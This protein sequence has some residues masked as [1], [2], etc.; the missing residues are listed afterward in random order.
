MSRGHSRPNYADEGAA[1]AY[2]THAK[3]SG[4]L[5]DAGPVFWFVFCGAM[6]IAAIALGT[7]L[8][9]SNFRDRAL[10]ATERQLENTVQLLT[11]HFDRQLEDFES[12]QKSVAAEIQR[13]IHSPEQLKQL[14]S[15]EGFHRY[16]RAKVS[17]ASDFAGINI[18]DADG[19]YINSSEKWPIPPINLSDRHYF[20]E[21]KS[22][23]TER[24]VLIELVQSHISNGRTVIVARKI[25]G[26]AGEF[27]GVV[28]RS[29]SPD[30]F[31]SFF[32]SVVLEDGAI[33]LLQQDGTMIARYPHIEAAVG[34]NFSGSPLFA[35]IGPSG[36]Y[37]TTHLV[38][39][40]DGQERLAAA[41][42]LSLYPLTVVSSQPVSTALVDWREQTRVLL[43][44]ACATAGVISL[45]LWFVTRHL[46]RQH[47]RLDVAVNHMTQ[48][49][50][51]FD[52]SE[53]LSAIAAI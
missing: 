27:L 22:G 32:S 52:P 3:Q 40:V 21:L 51:L 12:I 48:A 6:L 26:P 11:R 1:L 37:V 5:M 39:P 46:K 16:L 17:E 50:L 45:M 36:R 35:R 31:E 29:I 7:G 9:I 28:T 8:M 23:S 2:F 25:S 14:L 30:V 47:R 44:A 24:Q 49:L 13:Q 43:W 20:Q 53:R 10:A 15:T 33:N 19:G 34:R 42:R 38:S 41:G 4:F 18:F